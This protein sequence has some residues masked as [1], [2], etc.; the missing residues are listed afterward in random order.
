MLGASD[1]TRAPG[2]DRALNPTPCLPPQAGSGTHQGQAGSGGSGGRRER[3]PRRQG[4]V[5]S[6]TVR[7]G[8]AGQSGRACLP[9]SLS[10]TKP[11]GDP[12]QDS[13]RLGWPDPRAAP[14]RLS[15]PAWRP[16]QPLL[17][18]ML[19]LSPDVTA[20]SAQRQKPAGYSWLA[21]GMLPPQGR[22]GLSPGK[23]GDAQP[24]RDP[25]A[26]TSG[27]GAPRLR[28]RGGRGRGQG[29]LLLL[30]PPGTA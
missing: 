1:G 29:Y 26:V 4:I 3:V 27:P 14:T 2:V 7:E 11:L 15:P 19:S 18:S 5:T 17:A 22:N 6:P 21:Q 12:H 16:C 9:F 25:R 20:G 24:R 8:T 10:G 28:R 13:P 23:P 30:G